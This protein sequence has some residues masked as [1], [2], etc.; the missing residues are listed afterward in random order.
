MCSQ[1]E[2]TSYSAVAINCEEMSWRCQ[3]LHLSKSSLWLARLLSCVCVYLLLGHL[4]DLSSFCHQMEL[5]PSL[6]VY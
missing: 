2:Y 1:G 3:A 6:S 4:S 5:S